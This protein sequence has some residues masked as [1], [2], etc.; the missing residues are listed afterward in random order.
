MQCGAPPPPEFL[1]D[2]ALGVT[3]ADVLRQRGFVVE[4]LRSLYGEQRAQDIDDEEWIPECVGLGFV[5]LT[6][7]DAIRRYPPARD[8]AL[9]VAARIFCLPNASL[10]GP[11]IHERFLANLNRIVQRARHPGPYMYAVDPDGLRLLWPKQG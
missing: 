11:H 4:T 7:D 2:R 6:K 1:I 8:A 9:A 3:L 10:D 5:L